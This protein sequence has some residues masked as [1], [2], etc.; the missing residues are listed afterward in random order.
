DG[1]TTVA[2]IADRAVLVT[3]EVTRILHR[4]A[5]VELIVAPGRPSSMKVRIAAAARP[6]MILEPDRDGFHEPLRALLQNRTEPLELVDPVHYL[7]LSHLIAS[8]CLAAQ[9]VTTMPA[10]AQR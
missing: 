4:L 6:V 10:R 9:A 5:K 8:S 2:A 1:R 3:K 7:D